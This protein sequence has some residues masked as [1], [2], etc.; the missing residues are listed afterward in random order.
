MKL[1]HLN[2][3]S[4]IPAYV[5]C[6]LGKG[7]ADLRQ[8]LPCLC[9]SRSYLQIHNLTRHKINLSYNHQLIKKSSILWDIIPCIPLKVSRRFGGTYRLH[10]QSRRIRE[11]RNRYEACSRQCFTL[12]S[13]LDYYSKLKIET[14]CSSETSVDFQRTAR[15]YVSTNITLQIFR[16][17]ILTLNIA[18]KVEALVA[19]SRTKP[20]ERSLW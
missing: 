7:G 12:V 15:R 1:S 4:I 11:V 2:Y 10:L 8:H 17:I 18:S 5:K 19:D 9:T 6:V 20:R 14:T 16:V 3:T 13:F